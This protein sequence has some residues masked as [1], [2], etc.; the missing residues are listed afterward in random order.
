MASL[1][2]LPTS[3]TK[4]LKRVAENY[5]ARKQWIDATYAAL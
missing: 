1:G 3:T 2:T 4:L 5:A